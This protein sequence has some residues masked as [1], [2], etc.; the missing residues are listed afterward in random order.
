M[1]VLLICKFVRVCMCI[2]TYIHTYIHTYI[3][4]HTHTHIYIYVYVYYHIYIYIYIH[5]HVC[6]LCF[7]LRRLLQEKILL[8]SCMLISHHPT[9]QKGFERL[10][11]DL[12]D[13]S[14]YLKD[15]IHK[16]L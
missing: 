5:T 1:L 10:I 8:L 11:S 3:R 14:T 9:K 15:S 7:P 12:V 6:I 13:S 16:N 2:Y 4:T